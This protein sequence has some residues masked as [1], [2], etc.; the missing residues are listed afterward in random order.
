MMN[1]KIGNYWLFL[2]ATLLLSSAIPVAAQIVQAPNGQGTVIKDGNNQVV[3]SKT[4]IEKLWQLGEEQYQNSQFIQAIATYEQIL[5]LYLQIGDSAGAHAELRA[6]EAEALERI[7]TMHDFLG[8][9]SQALELYQQALAIKKEHG[10]RAGEGSLLNSIGNIYYQQGEYSQALN[11]YQQVLAIRKEVGDLIGEGRTLNNIGLVYN[12]WGQY[13]QAIEYFEQALKIVRVASNFKG[14]GASLNNL[15]LVYSQLGQY[16]RA[17]KF[18]QQALVVRRFIA[19]N[20]GIGTTLHNMGL[21]YDQQKQY[22]LALEL[23]QQALAVRQGAN[24]KAGEGITINNIGLAYNQLGDRAQALQFLQQALKIFQEIG[25]RSSEGNTFD[26]LGTVYKSLGDYQQS[27][28]SYQQALTI[29]KELGNRDLERLVLS[30]IAQL[31]E[32]EQ[33]PELAVFF[34]KQSINLTETIRQDL[35][36]L[37]REQQQSYTETVADPYR[38]LANLLLQQN[39]VLEAQQVLDL[40]KIQELDN[41]LHDVRGNEKTS[42]GVDLLPPEEKVEK[43]YNDL[44]D[45]AIKFGKELTKIRN[46]SEASR[47]PEQ[48]KKLAELQA[49][50][51]ELR[52]EFNQFI[53]SPTV[54]ALI[55]QLNKTTNGENINLE[56][57]NKLQ[58]QLK[59]LQQNAVFL[60]PLVLEDR[61]E[62]VLVTAD[63]PP[64]HRP[65]AINRKDVNQAIATFRTALQNPNSD[66][67]IPAQKLYN[68][69]IKP[70]AADLEQAGAQTIIYAPDGQL[71]YIPLGALHDGEQWLAQRFRIN[72]I[73]ALSLTDLDTKPS[74]KPHLLA[75]AFTEGRYT[76]KVKNNEFTFA[77]LPF[78]GQEVEKLATMVPETTKLLDRNFSR[79]ATIDRMNDYNIVHLATHAAFVLGQ[80]EESFILFGDGDR[81]TLRDVATW[82]LPDVDLIVLSACETGV[83]GQLGNG[84]E[85]LG[86]GYQM[87]KTGAR[88]AVASLWAVSDGGTQALMSAFYTALAEGKL[89]KA[90]ALHQAQIALITGNY[91]A[92]G[93]A[94]GGVAVE[95]LISS[96]LPDTVAQRLSHPYYWAPF[97][98]IGNGL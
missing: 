25:D 73:T 49:F 71:R 24:D 20:V 41:Y 8:E 53:N 91:Q 97:I 37:P 40:L 86:F 74:H 6:G 77:G 75:A 84:E 23:Y 92:L 15:G 18:Y 47:T 59:R 67:K 3:E 33:K 34:Y 21:I 10:D 61:I 65:V 98:L 32:V 29:V 19:D 30:N 4:E 60:Y 51:R 2:T 46:I 43:D 26:S 83:G 79:A 22:K 69:L 70:I 52:Q 7:G 9:Y 5:S 62:L 38:K 16:D 44:Q 66:A 89:T 64:I 95:A 82:S 76:F 58:A 96:K 48:Q 88:A 56:I 78:A 54:K 27:L 63:S 80:P 81:V 12:S 42:K 85:I 39:R 45:K 1:F 94:R 31:L 50:Q 57:L 90:N 36:K 93:S 35:K 68:L 14:I 28:N 17:F 72:N 13:P 11:F 87:Q 55:N